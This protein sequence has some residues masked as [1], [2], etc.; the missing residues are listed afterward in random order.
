MILRE[1]EPVNLEMPFGTLEGF[2]TPS[3]RF[4]VRGYFPIPQIDAKTWRLKVGGAVE[5]PFELNDT[6][7]MMMKS[8][9]VS[10]PL[11]CAGNSRAFLPSDS[12]SVKLTERHSFGFKT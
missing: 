7:L 10:A 1:K 5:K 3:E 2:I 6:E 4:Y 11:E 12:R 9:T 8:R